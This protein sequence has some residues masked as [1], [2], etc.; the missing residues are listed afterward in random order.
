MIRKSISF[1]EAHDAWM[2]AKIASGQ[3]ASESELIRDLIRGRQQDDKAVT[4][5]PEEIAAIR[6][7]LDKAEASGWSDRTLEEIRE[8]ARAQFMSRNSKK[9]S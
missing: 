7:I 2:K 9:A 6:A 5:T 8:D 1:T 4:E 3:Y